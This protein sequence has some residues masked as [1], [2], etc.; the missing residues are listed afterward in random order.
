MEH[1]RKRSKRVPDKLNEIWVF[2]DA[3]D[4]FE[5]PV[6]ISESRSEI[7]SYFNQRFG[8]IRTAYKRKTRLIDKQ[9]RKRLSIEVVSV[10]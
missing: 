9:S 4:E 3:Y 1:K 10:E 7:E 5:L 8:D 6:F 2:S